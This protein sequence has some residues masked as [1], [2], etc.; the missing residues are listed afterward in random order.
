MARRGMV[1][2]ALARLGS[3]RQAEQRRAKAGVDWRGGKV[4][5]AMC[6]LFSFFVLLSTTLELRR[7]PLMQLHFGDRH[8]EKNSGIELVVAGQPVAI[9]HHAVVDVGY[10][11][12]RRSGKKNF[13]SRSAQL[14]Q[15]RGSIASSS[16]GKTPESAP[17]M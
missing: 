14:F 16:G 3:A 1:R 15:S 17:I 2:R 11:H 12:A 8:I 9:E 7:A 4:G 5:A 13:R 6:R 10:D